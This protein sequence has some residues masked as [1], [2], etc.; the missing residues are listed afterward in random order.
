MKRVQDTVPNYYLCLKTGSNSNDG[1]ALTT[2]FKT[3]D[4]A[5]AQ[6]SVGQVLCVCEH[7]LDKVYLEKT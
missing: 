5:E 1:L 2:G 7:P 6:M 4:Y 3:L